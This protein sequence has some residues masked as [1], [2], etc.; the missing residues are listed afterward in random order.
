MVRTRVGYAGGSTTAPTYRSI[1][2]HSETIQ[3]DYDPE[4]V[5]FSELLD[6]FWS[7]HRPTSPA[8]SRQYASAIFTH[9]PEQERFARESKER[10]ESRLGPLYTDIV[11][12]DRFYVAE[13]YHQKYRLRNTR[14]LFREFEAMYPDAGDFRESTA[15]ARVNGYL[16]GYGTRSELE[17]QIDAFGMTPAGAELLRNA[18]SSGSRL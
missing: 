9:D 1:G 12:L 13:D 2:D 8:W 15:A 16:D 5:S 3:V 10:M 17:A 14:G 18:V 7:S 11:S 4:R 6:V